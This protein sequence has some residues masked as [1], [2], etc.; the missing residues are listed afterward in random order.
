M[1][2]VVRGGWLHVDRVGTLILMPI[3]QEW[4]TFQEYV[5]RMTL[6]RGGAPL[7]EAHKVL[8]ELVIYHTLDVFVWT[9]VGIRIVGLGLAHFLDSECPQSVHI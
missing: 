1:A 4:G 5:W 8:L 2:F 7:W 6:V 9:S 3:A